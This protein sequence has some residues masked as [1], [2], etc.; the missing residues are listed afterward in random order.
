MVRYRQRWIVQAWVCGKEQD[1]GFGLKR[2]RIVGE[3]Q[4]G[5]EYCGMGSSM[6]VGSCWCGPVEPN[7]KIVVAVF[8]VGKLIV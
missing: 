8:V 7:R 3:K 5:M 1:S 2:V 6:V 4:E